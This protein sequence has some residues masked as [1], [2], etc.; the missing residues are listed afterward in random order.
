MNGGLAIYE[1]SVFHR[2][3]KPVEHSFSY[4]TFMPMFDLAE[5]PGALDRVPMWSARRPAPARFRKTDF[6]A[7]REDQSLI[8]RARDL[9]EQRTG[10]RPTGAV[11]L[12][13]NPRWWGIGFNPVSFYYLHGDAPGSRPEVVLAEV[14]STPWRQRRVYA[15][16]R[17]GDGPLQG[18]VRKSMHVS[19]FNP[20]EQTYEW[21]IGEPGE[22]LGI[23]I[24]NHD[25]DGEDA[26]FE[27][28]LTMTRHEPTPAALR[29]LLF[30]Y[31]PATITTIGRIYAHALR[32]K[33]KG[34]PYYR[35]PQ[36][37]TD[38]KV[39]AARNRAH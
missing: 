11:S 12:L 4:R 18:M 25:P 32:L 28:G 34:A 23:S 8:E 22:R 13:A 37:P 26:T 15:L 36:S 17:D 30:R 1:G 6:L 5:L 21:E 27:A 7:C 29:A 10:R 16:A 31:P 38:G 39:G 24:R 14:T 9:A 19:P 33:L 2:R 3:R 20:L 35:R